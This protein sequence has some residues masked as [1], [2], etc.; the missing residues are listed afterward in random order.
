MPST[1]EADSPD[2]ILKC[3][4]LSINQGSGSEPDTRHEILFLG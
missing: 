1:R 2:L 4:Q 3:D